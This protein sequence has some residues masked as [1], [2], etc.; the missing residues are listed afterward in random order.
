MRI[1]PHYH[2]NYEINFM[3]KQ[4]WSIFHST[5][6]TYGKVYFIFTRNI[7]IISL[8]SN[9]ISLSYHKSIIQF[10]YNYMF[11]KILHNVYLFCNKKEV[12]YFF[13]F[14]ILTINDK[15]CTLWQHAFFLRELYLYKIFCLVYQWIHLELLQGGKLTRTIAVWIKIENVRHV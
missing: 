2:I 11:W 10:T 5:H 6:K 15:Q 13:Y 7:N 14:Y 9:I 4:Y 3:F 12:Y 1:F 8:I